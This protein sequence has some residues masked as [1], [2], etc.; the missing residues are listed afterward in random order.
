MNNIN[1]SIPTT[2]IV[3]MAVFT[4]P[5]QAQSPGSP[6]R[7]A[8][9]FDMHDLN[10]DGYVT[11]QEFNTFRGQRMSA[12]AAEGRPM[13]GAA[14]APS[15]SSFDA[16]RDGRLTQDEF[17]AGRMAHMQQRRGMGPGMGRGMGYGM[18]PGPGMG[19]G[20]GYGMGPGMGPCH[21]MRKQQ[22]G[23]SQYDTDGDGVI[24]ESEFNQAHQSRR[25]Q[26]GPQ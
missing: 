3:I 1:Q 9:P 8:T 23:F 4:L 19:R 2:L 26:Q 11:E 7:G 24:S 15:F 17:D 25:G 22:S 21:H 20:M 16:N 12:R 14:N 5:V 18:G 10:G 13:Y 6:M